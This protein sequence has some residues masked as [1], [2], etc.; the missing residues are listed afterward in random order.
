MVKIEQINYNLVK[1][2]LEHNVMKM[3]I[4][5][6]YAPSDG[7]IHDMRRHTLED[8]NDE[9]LLIGDM[10]T[11]CSKTPNFGN[12]FKANHFPIL[13]YLDSS[14]IFFQANSIDRKSVV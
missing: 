8:E 12:L 2:E 6:C 5:G 7:N 4:Y 13:L 11:G 3:S 14:E 9:I 1:I 10:N